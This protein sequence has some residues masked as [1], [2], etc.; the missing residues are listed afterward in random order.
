VADADLAIGEHVG[1]EA[2]LV[3]QRTKGARLSSR[4]GEALQV[5]ARLAESLPEAL[6]VPD[7]KLL[8]DEGIEIYATG[9]DIA[10]GFLWSETTSGQA[11]LVEH[12][13]LDEREVVSPAVVGRE[14]APALAVAVS[15]KTPTRVGVS[16][17]HRD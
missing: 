7:A 8:A 15:F 10:T 4:C 5:G 2:A 9:H 1:A 13:G 16:G 3:D 17:W 14:R 11:Q 12:F 6:D